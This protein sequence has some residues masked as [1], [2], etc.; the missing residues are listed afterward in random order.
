MIQSYIRRQELDLSGAH[1]IRQDYV[2]S[3]MEDPV[4]KKWAH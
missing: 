4:V 2:E 1:S 3:L